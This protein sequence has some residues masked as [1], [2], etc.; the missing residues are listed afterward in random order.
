VTVTVEI[1]R[2]IQGEQ[3]CRASLPD[4]AGPIRVGAL[5]QIMG[6]KATGRKIA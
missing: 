4:E 2:Q 3:P 6:R 5:D 1:L